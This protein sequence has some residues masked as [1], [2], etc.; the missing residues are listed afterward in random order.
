MID[1][2]LTLAYRRTVQ[3]ENV[4]P[5]SALQTTEEYK[6]A[7]KDELRRIN[8]LGLGAN[9]ASRDFVSYQNKR[10]IEAALKKLET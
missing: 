2:Y 9:L 10:A 8:K 7:L 6:A 1:K 5:D 3:G 4:D